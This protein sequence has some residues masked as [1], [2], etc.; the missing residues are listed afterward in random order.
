MTLDWD[1]VL[2]KYRDGAE[3]DSLP[4]AATLSVSGADE[5]K[6]YVKHR[7]WKD[8]LSRTNLERAIEMVSAGTMTRIA[9]DFI[10]QYRTIIADERPTTA[11]TVLKDLG[12]L[13]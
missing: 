4:G 13:D 11:A 3:I 5:E 6:I 8:S 1:N 10:D 7:L 2:E 9:A 12:Y